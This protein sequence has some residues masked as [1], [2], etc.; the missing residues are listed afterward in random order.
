MGQRPMVMGSAICLALNLP[1]PVLRLFRRVK[2]C[3]IEPGPVHCFAGD[4]HPV[5]HLS[6]AL[7]RVYFLLLTSV[8][9]F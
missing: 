3:R 5:V 9:V 1:T 2:A 6:Q 8:L 4:P 7:V